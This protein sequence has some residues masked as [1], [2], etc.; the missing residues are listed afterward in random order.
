VDETA[1]GRISGIVKAN[2]DWGSS[3][4]TS[5][6]TKGKSGLS[7]KK[8]MN[9]KPSAIP[10]IQSELAGRFQEDTGLRKMKPD[11]VRANLMVPLN[12]FG[13]PAANCRSCIMH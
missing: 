1:C 5:E 12:S 2:H 8:T 4:G 3:G 6:A 9:D 7:M 10:G 11:S 13:A